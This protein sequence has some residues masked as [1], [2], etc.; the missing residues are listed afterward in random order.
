MSQVCDKARYCDLG[1]RKWRDPKLR[2]KGKEMID[3]SA[4]SGGC[5]RE[6]LMR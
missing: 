4:I 2:T 1:K 3:G 5:G 6:L